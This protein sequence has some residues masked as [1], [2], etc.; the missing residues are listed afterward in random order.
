[1]HRPWSK[2][3]FPLAKLAAAITLA[4]PWSRFERRYCETGSKEEREWE[5]ERER[6]R[7]REIS[8]D[9]LLDKS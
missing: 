9:M 5:R 8:G 7:E 6:E 4:E 1:M 3:I 2:D